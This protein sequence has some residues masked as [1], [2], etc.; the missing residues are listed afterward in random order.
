MAGKSLGTL[1]L[2]LVANVGGFKQGLDQSQ[3]QAEQWR[4]NV[5]STFTKVASRIV[6]VGLAIEGVTEAIDLLKES[7]SNARD[8]DNFSKSLGTSSTN[9]Q[10]WQYAASQAGINGEKLAD[11][12]KDINDKIGDAAL[13]KTGAA[14]DALTQLSLSAEQLRK[15]SP[16]QILEKIGTALSNSNYTQAE[17]TNILESLVND[18]TL[19]EPLLD[20]NN[21]KLNQLKQQALDRGVIYSQQD[22]ENLTNVNKLFTQIN[23]VDT[24]FKNKI[25]S[26]LASVDFS[27]LSEGLSA[28]SSFIA[29]PQVQENLTSAAQKISDLAS[30]IVRI[31]VGLERLNEASKNFGL[32]KFLNNT[33]TDVGKANANHFSITP[34]AGI[35]FPPVPTDNRQQRNAG[36]TI[37]LSKE[38]HCRIYKKRRFQLSSPTISCFRLMMQQ[39]IL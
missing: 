10:E 14:A 37:P 31:A 28:L 23:D 15:L 9:L 39:D 24:A 7:S 25:A 30:G 17:K 21:Q 11:M 1:T 20:N 12:F 35:S 22:I 5:A 13:N 16:D 38:T 33:L 36:G 3:R 29:S 34:E 19:L 2:D 6:P 27:S 18:A 4:R 8:I 26:A 32:V